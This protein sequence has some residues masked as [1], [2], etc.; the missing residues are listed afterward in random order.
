M[1]SPQQTAE[2][3]AE[4]IAKQIAV[5]QESNP[6]LNLHHSH[7]QKFIAKRILT[8]LNLAE[9]LKEK[10]RLDWLDNHR[11]HYI[12]MTFK[13]HESLAATA[14]TWREAIT[15]AMN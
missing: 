3:L 7:A 15:A 10:E 13:Y 8:E 11:T 9:L 6:H 2:E 5:Y 14:K 12:Y 4:K 1:N